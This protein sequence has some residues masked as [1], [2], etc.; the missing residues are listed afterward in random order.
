MAEPLIETSPNPERQNAENLAEFSQ[1]SEVDVNII[2]S[3]FNKNHKLPM[4]KHENNQWLDS[5]SYHRFF[6]V[7]KHVLTSAP[8]QRKISLK[9]HKS[10]NGKIALLRREFAREIADKPQVKIYEIYKFK[11]FQ[12]RQ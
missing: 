1:N 10:K 5:P 3:E 4:N 7:L 11:Y 12:N 9:K 8:K 2:S 6:C